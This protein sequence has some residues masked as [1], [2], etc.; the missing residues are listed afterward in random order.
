MKRFV[1]GVAASLLAWAALSF[2]ANRGGAGTA[3][4]YQA[5]NGSVTAPTSPVEWVK[6]NAG[7]ANAHYIESQSIPYRL[8]LT[9][10]TNGPHQLIIEWDV[11][12]KGKSAIDYLTH[13]DRL[14]PHDLFPGHDTP[15]AI[16]PLAGLAGP[17]GPS[18]L[19]PIPPPSGTN[20]PVPGQPALSFNI[21]PDS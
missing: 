9:G 18:H 10:L 5:R 20:S 6:G 2:G 12:Q 4:L 16:E 13:Y 11:R 21:L 8:V 7:P 15:E 17:F 19:F 14:L 1:H 3:D